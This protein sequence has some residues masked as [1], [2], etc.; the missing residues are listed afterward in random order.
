[1]VDDFYLSFIKEKF[2]IYDSNCTRAHVYSHAAR[3]A[4]NI[5]GFTCFLEF[6]KFQQ[7]KMI[8]L[9]LF[10]DIGKFGV[11]PNTL[12]KSDC[13]S[14]T[15]IECIRKHSIFGED[16]LKGINELSFLSSFIRHHHERWDG[17]GY[18]DGL[19]SNEIPYEC[20]ILSLADAF[21]A[22][23]SDRCYRNALSIE[24][25]LKEIDMDKGRQFDP[26]LSKQFI[27]YIELHNYGLNNKFK[28]SES[29]NSYNQMSYSLRLL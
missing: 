17:N 10:H 13:L 18:P 7:Y 8:R 11:E 4:Q 2:T 19:T 23:I 25:A 24:E 27:T 1:M 9:A 29:E 28:I 16:Y 5:L 26:Y 21:D 3:V 14:P 12:F 22:M 15:D 20:R 6:D